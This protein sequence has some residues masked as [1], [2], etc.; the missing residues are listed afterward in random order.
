MLPEISLNI[1]D[2]AQNSISAG[3]SRIGITVNTQTASRLLTVIIEDNGH[4]MSAE[5]LESVDDPFFTTRTTRDVGLGIPFFR[6]E[7]EATGGSFAIASDP[8]A[9]TIVTAVFCTDHIDCVP[10]GDVNATI[11]SLVT[12]EPLIDFCYTRIVDGQSFVM[13]TAQMREILGG[14][15][16]DSPEVSSFLAD[17]LEENEN[18]LTARQ[19]G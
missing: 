15:P 11:R 2:I 19:S 10:L 8:G 12:M 14:V 5:V 9:G 13:D 3:A 6:Q 17:F 1:L 16:L 18:E 7:A 4:G